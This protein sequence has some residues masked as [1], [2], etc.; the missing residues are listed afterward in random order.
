MRI[1]LLCFSG[2]PDRVGQVGHPLRRLDE[3]H[4]CVDA[5][6]RHGLPQPDGPGSS[7]YVRHRRL[8]G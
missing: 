7:A 2:L 5:D 8:G 3:Q 6:Q 4:P 1:E